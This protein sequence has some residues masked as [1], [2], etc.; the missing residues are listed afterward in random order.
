[1]LLLCLW[2]AR[3][4]Q[5]ESDLSE[6]LAKKTCFRTWRDEWTGPKKQLSSAQDIENNC[7]RLK[8]IIFTLRPWP[9]FITCLL[10]LGW[11][12]F[13]DVLDAAFAGRALT[14][15]SVSKVIRLQSAAL[16]HMTDSSAHSSALLYAAPCRPH[17]GFHI[18]D[19]WLHLDRI[20]CS[21]PSMGRKV[22]FTFD[23]WALLTGVTHID[24][25]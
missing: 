9:H 17:N 16:W 20:T 8:P 1:M 4:Y 7:L 25:R 22:D 5:I 23:L 12:A 21:P 14:F 10:G 18:H 24:I 13:C 15:E 11:A 6:H 19:R 2:Q 3:R